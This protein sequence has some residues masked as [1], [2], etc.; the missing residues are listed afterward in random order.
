MKGEIPVTGESQV[1]S[2]RSEQAVDLF[3][4]Y[5]LVERGLSART[6][7]AYRADL[8]AF[9]ESLEKSGRDYGTGAKTADVIEFA[10][11]QR[12]KGVGP[13]SL[14]RKLSALRTFYKMCA[15]EKL[16]DANPLER[17][18]SPKLWRSLPKT[19]TAEG[20]RRLVEVPDPDSPGGM[21]DRAMLEVLYGSGL[22]VSEVCDLKLSSVDFTVGF[23]RT[24]GKGSKER[25]VPLGKRAREAM[26]AYLLHGRPSLVAR[27]KEDGFFLNRFGKRISRQSVWKIVKEASA[28]AGL[29]PDTSPHTLRHSFATHLLEGGADL[30]SL[31]MMLGHSDLAT[32]QIY[33]H[34]SRGRLRDLVRKHH[35]RG[36]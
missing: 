34:V 21:R 14:A 27:A 6:V 35:P 36:A 20:A 13:R 15:R 18:D 10:R 9:L 29:P 31:Q 30:R 4:E 16:S 22:R 5:L 2:P 19:L 11:V 25:V 26:E 1:L 32:T 12:E 17:M 3:V 7:D 8:R 24:L 28:R 33:T 23:I